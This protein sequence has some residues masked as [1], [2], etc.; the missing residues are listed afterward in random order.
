MKA[1]YKDRH[2][3]GFKGLE[4]NGIRLHLVALMSKYHL[5]AYYMKQNLTFSG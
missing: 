3:N 4:Q 5:D 2:V 1:C